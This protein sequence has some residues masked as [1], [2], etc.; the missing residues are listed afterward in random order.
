MILRVILCLFDDWFDVPRDNITKYLMTLNLWYFQVVH[1]RRKHDIIKISLKIQSKDQ[2]TSA[3]D[4][5]EKRL[6]LN[7]IGHNC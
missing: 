2:S 5:V 7:I 1:N 4:N 6:K 3:F